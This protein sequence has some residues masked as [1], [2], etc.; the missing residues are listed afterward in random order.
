MW[1]PSAFM[2]LGTRPPTDGPAPLLRDVFA[3]AG[4]FSIGVV[5]YKALG[6]RLGGEGRVDV[7]ER[8]ADT[9]LEEARR[10]ER[11]ER[12]GSV[13][14]VGW[15]QPGWLYESS[16]LPPLPASMPPWLCAVVQGLVRPP[17]PPP[18]PPQL[19]AP[20]PFHIACFGMRRRS[21]STQ[22]PRRCRAEQVSLFVPRAMEPFSCRQLAGD[23]G[24]Q[25]DLASIDRR[26][27]ELV[28]NSACHEETVWHAEKK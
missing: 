7:F 4:G 23:P 20:N 18:R 22:C 11:G 3:K 27:T 9:H 6:L 15:R 10:V 26:P 1:D 24:T 8:L 16:E 17:T 14:G 21:C 12:D 28:T 2:N 5:V 25:C 13:P 19:A